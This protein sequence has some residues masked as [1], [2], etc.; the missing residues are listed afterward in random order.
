MNTKHTPGPWRVGI[1]LFDGED[2]PIW[3]GEPD[4][5]PC[6]AVV[7]PMTGDEDDRE[8]EANARLIAAA[9]EMVA[10]MK[11]ARVAFYDEGTSKA[12]RPVMADMVALIRRLEA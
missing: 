5:A 1:D 7:W 12:L 2:I 4:K 9:P 10:V 11:R 3:A 8:P 6:V